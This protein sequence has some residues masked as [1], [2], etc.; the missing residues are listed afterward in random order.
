MA[1]GRDSWEKIDYI[2]LLKHAHTNPRAQ[3]A[4][5]RYQAL[6][7]ELKIRAPWAKPEIRYSPRHGY[8]VSDPLAI[9]RPPR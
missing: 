5:K 2:E 4:V 3:E 6:A 1:R 9:E 7:E 8:S